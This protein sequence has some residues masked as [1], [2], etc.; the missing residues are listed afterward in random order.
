MVLSPM[1]LK[2]L[3]TYTIES[4][5]EVLSD[6]MVFNRDKSSIILI[7]ISH[8]HYTQYL[9][10]DFLLTIDYYAK[11]LNCFHIHIH[12]FP[13]GIASSTLGGT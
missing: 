12:H 13:T 1:Q 8:K 9:I 4:D 3:T 5:E 7:L 11:Q 10:F 2:T 6:P